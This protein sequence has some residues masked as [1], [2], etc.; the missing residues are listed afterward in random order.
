MKITKLVFTVLTF[1]MIIFIASCQNLDLS[2][3]PQIPDVKL[4]G[5]KTPLT[6]AKVIQG[7][8]EALKIGSGNSVVKANKKNGF[9]GDSR[10]KIPF[11]KDAEFVKNAVQSVPIIGPKLVDTLILKL[12]RAAENAA[13]KAKPILVDAITKI[14]IKDAMNILKGSNNAATMYLKSNA[15]NQLAKAFKPGIQKSLEDV[16]AQNAWK[17]LTTKYN[18]LPVTNKVNTDLAQYTTE[19]ALDGLFTLVADEELKIRKDPVARVT[20]ILKEVFGK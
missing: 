8:K 14:T 4:P 13:M 1:I 10:I 15:Y 5:Q 6:E 2:K 20:D 16:G 11:P 3:I 9:F 18:S 17:S 19:K 7:L 12:N